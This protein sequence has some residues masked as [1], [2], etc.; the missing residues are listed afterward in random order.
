M[1]YAYTFF[2]FIWC[3]YRIS[4]PFE[5][6]DII[7]QYKNVDLF[8]Y[9]D[10]QIIVHLETFKSWLRDDGA[11][12]NVQTTLNG[13]F[14]WIESIR[15]ES[16]LSITFVLANLFMRLQTE[17]CIF[18]SLHFQKVAIHWLGIHATPSIPITVALI[19]FVWH[20]ELSPSNLV[21]LTELKLFVSI[22]R[23]LLASIPQI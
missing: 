1:K 8:A 23:I 13:L 19:S 6:I 5:S 2:L 10:Y 20:L 12:V 4:S 11:L 17:L 15:A 21:H 18:P 9:P 7:F 22:A 3:V 14:H 16:L